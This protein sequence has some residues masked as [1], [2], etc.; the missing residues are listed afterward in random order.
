[1]VLE[2][3]EVE[4]ET[5]SNKNWPDKPSRTE[6]VTCKNNFCSR[7][8]RSDRLAGQDF[9][10]LR[11]GSRIQGSY[12]RRRQFWSVL[13]GAVALCANLYDGRRQ[14]VEVQMPGDVVHPFGAVDGVEWAVEALS[15]A[16]LCELTMSDVD[17]T[18]P[19]DT[20]FLKTM[21]D[22]DHTQ[23]ARLAVH[24]V[25]LG[26]LDG[27]ERICQ[28]LADMARRQGRGRETDVEVSLPMSRDDIA[29]YLG[30]KAETVSRLLGRIRKANL[31]IFESPT[32]C[33]I[34]NVD[35]LEKHARI[36]LPRPPVVASL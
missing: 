25:G 4:M 17:G 8:S 5:G 13:D 15:D 11:R 33:L 1:M 24:S 23:L 22:Y 26:R 36:F 14:I 35:A 16:R 31:A 2:N 18:S 3:G 19:E 12:R 6:C 29:D 9:R 20:E 21:S 10:T 28:F 27:T 7:L 32:R 34:P 30:L